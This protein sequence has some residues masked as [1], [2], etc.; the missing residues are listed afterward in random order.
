MRPGVAWV[1][2]SPTLAASLEFGAQL[3]ANL[4]QGIELFFGEL[5][6]DV[7]THGLNMVGRCR[8]ETVHTFVGEHSQPT[9]AVVLTLLSTNQPL[10]LHASDLVGQ[11]TAADE[12]GLCQV[13]HAHMSLWRLREAHKDLVLRQRKS[14]LMA[15]VTLKLF[16]QECADADKSAP[17]LLLTP[18]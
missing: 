14:M 2:D 8:H 4:G 16:G 13:R 9:A 7:V 5:V 3:V 15:E 11:P 17:L 18:V 1:R 6:H 10:S 12:G